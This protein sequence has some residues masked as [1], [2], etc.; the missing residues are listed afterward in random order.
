MSQEIIKQFLEGGYLNARILFYYEN[1]N[2]VIRG[3]LRAINEE[4]FLLED[5][6]RSIVDP[7]GVYAVVKYLDGLLSKDKEPNWKVCPDGSYPLEALSLDKYPV[8]KLSDEKSAK[9]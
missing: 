9:S 1:Q 5:S 3:R 7:T 6:Q 2:A 8:F 4:R